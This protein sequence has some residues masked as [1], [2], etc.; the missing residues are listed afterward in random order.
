MK[1]LLQINS[2]VNSGSTGHIAEEIGL[3]AI[4]NGW[5]SYIASGRSGQPSKSESIIIGNAWDIRLHGIQTRLFDRHGLGSYKASLA[6]VKKIIN[7]KPDIIHL[8]NLHGYYL[9]IEVL[10]IFLATQS[11]PVV[12]TF[13]DCWPMTGH[14]AHF[15]FIGCEKWKTECNECPQKNKYPTSFLLDRSSKNHQLKKQLFSLPEYMTIVTVSQWLSDTTRQ[16]F[17]KKYPIK[18]INNGI[19]TTVFKPSN[20]DLIRAKYN[21]LGKFVILGVANIWSVS[22]GLNDLIELS[23]IIDSNCQIVLIGLNQ[24][25]IEN[26]PLNIIGIVRTESKEELAEMYSLA[27]VYVNTSVEETFGLTTAEALSCGTPAVVY[28]ATACPEV[29]SSETGFIVEKGDIKGLLKAIETVRKNGKNK[30]SKACRERAITLYDKND[31]YMEYF[32]LYESILVSKVSN[33][34]IE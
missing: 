7:I 5:N 2:V 8:H 28:N 29:I 22:K 21:I 15:D 1:T 31:R 27:D 10:F 3:V 23:K 32:K 13:H 33:K 25:Q 11:I 16:S 20:H 14:C 19:D 26:L 30:Y 4:N 18:I 17:L 24:R 34:K 12:W 6:L 9:N